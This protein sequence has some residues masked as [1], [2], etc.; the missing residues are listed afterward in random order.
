MFIFRLAVSLIGACAVLAQVPNTAYVIDTFAGSDPFRDGGPAAQALLVRPSGIAVDGQGN[1]WIADVG[2]RAIRRIAPDGVITTAAGGPGSTVTEGGP[3]VGQ[4]LF[5]LA[6]VAADNQGNVFFAETTTSTVRRLSADGRLF[7]YAGTRNRFGN[8]GD[9]GPAASAQLNRAQGLATDTAGNLY[10]A[11]S[12]NYTVRR[13]DA[14]SG[15][16]TT[17][18]GTGQ[19]GFS[20][21]GGPATE[22]QLG[23]PVGVAFES[24]GGLLIADSN[25]RRIRRVS[26]AGIISTFAGGGSGA[27]TDGQAAT[28]V[29]FPS[30]SGVAVRGTTVYVTSSNAVYRIN[31]AGQ[32]FRLV[33]QTGFGGDGG[34]AAEARVSGLAGVAVDSEGAVLLTDSGNHRVRRI[35]PDGVITTIAGSTYLAGDGAPASEAS[36]LDPVDVAA[37]ARGNVYI[38]EHGARVIRRVAPDGTIRVVAGNGESGTLVPGR[39][40]LETPLSN[41][42]GIATGREGRVYFCDATARR[43][44]RIV[45]GTVELVAGSGGSGQ[46]GDGGPATQA[47]FIRP[48]PLALDADGNLYIADTFGYRIRKVDVNGIITTVAGTGV[49]GGSGDGGPAAEAQISG[50]SNLFFDAAGNLVLADNHSLKV[51]Q[52]APDGT[53]T[54]IATLNGNI[55][56]AA[57]EQNGDVLMANPNSQYLAAARPDGSEGRAISS[58]NAGFAG[59]GGP[60]RSARFGGIGRMSAAPDGRVFIVDGANQRIRVLLPVPTIAPNA[61]LNSADFKPAAAPGSIL[62]AFGFNLANGTASATATPVP[63][64]LAGATSSITDSAGTVHPAPTFFARPTQRNFHVPETAAPGEATLTIA[65][66]FGQSGSA[67]FVITPIAPALYTFPGTGSGVAAAVAERIGSDGSRNPVPL[68][69]FNQE[70]AQWEAVPMSLGPEGDAVYLTLFGTGIR[71]RSGLAGVTVTLGGQNVP[72]LYAGEQGEFLGLDQVNAGP[73]PRS[74]AGAGEVPL[75]LTVDGTAANAILL[76]VQ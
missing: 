30:V 36:L 8:T 34:P 23:F 13:V 72:V 49:S 37:D 57:Y 1:I 40:A 27:F 24:Q 28:E 50:V 44:Y 6:G 76:A 62:S 70:T 35:A 10:I 19:T 14:A 42:N 12:S 68:A 64:E 38:A 9:G 31:E 74:L 58:G 45:D 60:V 46:A 61:I 4:R 73:I 20:G 7:V 22:A 55:S 41:L 43:I 16:I 5:D 48:G 15:I 33:S 53:I 17:V 25:S 32:T 51:R 65:N 21:D 11:D 3:A 63:A 67:T 75:Q 18:A 66:Q 39:P 71:G 69:R 26:P 29:N 47:Q 59:D 56:G 52:I 54:T 2:N